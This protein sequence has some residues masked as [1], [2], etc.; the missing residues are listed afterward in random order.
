MDVAYH[1]GS[2]FLSL[3][4]ADQKPLLSPWRSQWCSL[5]SRRTWKNLEVLCAQ[6][7]SVGSWAQ[8]WQEGWRNS[9]P[10]G[11]RPNP[12]P[13]PQGVGGPKLLGCQPR[14][15]LVTMTPSRPKP[16]SSESKQ[17]LQPEPTVKFLFT[18][19]SSVEP[20]EPKDPQA[21]F[22]ALESRFLDE[23]DWGSR[24]T[25]KEINHLQNACMG[26]QE[27]MST[28]QA[29]NVALKEKLQNLPNLVYN[30]LVEELKAAQEEDQV[31]QE[32]E[33]ASHETWLF[34][35]ARQPHGEW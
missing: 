18:L 27:S 29:D 12:Q 30:I 20:S 3:P 26:L 14:V 2:V 35:V 8:R 32:E 10:A 31:A 34:Q 16:S 25:S 9:F 21:E 5:L 4:R 1:L 6:P 11:R 15:T 7:R 28:I 13:V 22:E 33:E 19:L 23:E 17:D 24:Q